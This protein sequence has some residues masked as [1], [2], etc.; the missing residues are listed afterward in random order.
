MK[1]QSHTFSE[2]LE[3]VR[4]RRPI[5]RPNTGYKEQ[6][7][8]YSQCGCNFTEDNLQFQQWKRRRDEILMITPF[9]LGATPSLGERPKVQD[10]NSSS[11]MNMI[12]DGL[13]LGE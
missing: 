7:E 3:F 1:T 13:W 8:I 12:L 2:V 5:V 10:A 11:N 6:L 4:A 9:A